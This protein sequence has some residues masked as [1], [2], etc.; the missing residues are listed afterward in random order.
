LVGAKFDRFAYALRAAAKTRNALSHRVHGGVPSA[1]LAAAQQCSHMRILTALCTIVLL[2]STGCGFAQSFPIRP[3]RVIVPFPPGG[4]ADVVMRVLAP[5]LGDALGQP[6]VID[7]RAGA[8]GNIGTDLAAHALADGYT[9]LIATAAQAVNSTLSKDIA[10]D[11]NKS[12]APVSL[13]VKNQILLVARPSLGV[14]SV[15]DLIIMA[16]SNPGKITYASYGTGSTAHMSAELFKMMSG[17]D[18]LHVPYKG[19]A[20]A[21]NDVVAGQ[22][23]IVFADVAAILPFVKAGS[24]RALGFGSS[25]RFPGLPSVPTIAEAG[26]PGYETGGFLAL[27]AP[28][29]T[30]KTAID[31]LNAALVKVLTSAD[32]AEKLEA[33]GGLPSPDTPEQLGRFL[34]SD[35]D[36][37]AVVIKTAHISGN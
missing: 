25:S 12:F 26:V 22:V 19:A 10:W 5:A 9:V 34:K 18:L 27:V 11:L 31:V 14:T 6:I 3:V 21:I 1:T 16:K 36:K 30:P 28:I 35:V 23:D 20:P 24:V 33:Q 15:H 7:N 29:G 2:V 13:I 17:V 37:W 8:G 32:V 4:G